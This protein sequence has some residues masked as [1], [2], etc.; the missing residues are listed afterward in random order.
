MSSTYVTISV[1]ANVIH[2]CIGQSF[3]YVLAYVGY[4]IN[5]TFVN[6]LWSFANVLMH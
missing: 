4:D 1:Y 6:T 2:L 5:I 3:P